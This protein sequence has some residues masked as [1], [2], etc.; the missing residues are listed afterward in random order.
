MHRILFLL[1]A[2]VLFTGAAS[3]NFDGS[4]DFVNVG[5]AANLDNV[6]PLTL[7]VWMKPDGTGSAAGR[8]MYKQN[9]ANGNG[10]MGFATDGTNQLAF[11][12]DTDG[13]NLRRD[14]VDNI[15]T[16][17]VWQFVI[18]TWGGSTAGTSINIYVDGVVA[19][20]SLTQGSG[21]ALSDA[22]HPLYIGGQGGSTTFGGELAFARFEDAVLSEVER[23]EIM[24]KPDTIISSTIGLWHLFGDATEPDYSKNSNSGTVSGSV[25][26]IDGPPVMFGGGLPL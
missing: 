6:S 25:V 8:L 20:Y 21:S 18:A 17:N 11:F 13:T 10:W 2:W 14:T 23:E 7:S 5:S 3:R 16:D 1:I 12:R 26:S 4:N 15:F 24:W 19:T 9:T 22:V